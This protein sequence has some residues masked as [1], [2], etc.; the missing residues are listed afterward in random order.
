MENVK[1]THSHVAE[2][3]KEDL[4]AAYLYREALGVV[5][6][7]GEKLA[8]IEKQLTDYAIEKAEVEKQIPELV[9]V[10]TVTPEV[11]TEVIE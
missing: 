1:G 4:T 5:T 11:A 7:G 8:E 6:A 10:V 9:P 3:T 2:M